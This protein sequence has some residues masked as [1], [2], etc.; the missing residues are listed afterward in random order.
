[1]RVGCAKARNISALNWR[2]ESIRPLYGC[3]SCGDANILIPGVQPDQGISRYSRRGEK[4][5]SSNELS[6]Q[7][8]AAHNGRGRV[9]IADDELNIARTLKQILLN[10]G[11]H[12]R[13]VYGGR[14]AVEA[15]TEWHPD[16]LL[17]DVHMPDM[18]GI[19]AAIQITHGMPNCKILLFTA[20]VVAYDLM[21]DARERGY[22][23][24]VLLKPVHPVELI[25]EVSAAL[26][27][28]SS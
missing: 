17:A 15:A 10:E 20:N 18:N 25:R 8:H 3:V 24:S 16:L 2:K 4:T 26:A 19:D 5:L 23:F 11:F 22:N 14:A 21:K 27:G 12:A 6:E 1:M 7:R 13:A 9:L 28:D